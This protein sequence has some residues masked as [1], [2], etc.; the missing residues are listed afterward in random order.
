MADPTVPA[1]VPEPAAPERATQVAEREQAPLDELMLA[2]DV[3]DTL[4]HRELVVARELS[5]EDRERELMQRLREIYTG[6]G[7]EVSDEILAQGVRALRE[8]RFVYSGPEPGFARSLA[9]LYV[10]RG[11]WGKPLLALLAVVAAG[12]LGYQLIVR[13][14]ELRSI[15]QLPGQLQ[16]AQQSVAA[17]TTDSRALDEATDLLGIGQTAIAQQDYD[18]A[19]RAVA[20]LHDLESKLEQQYELRVVS[21][22]GERSGVWRVPDDNRNARNYYLIVEALA[23]SGRALTLPIRNEEDGRTYNVDKWGLRVDESTYEAIARDKQDDGIIQ[24]SVVGAK[25]RGALDPEFAVQTTGATIT[26]W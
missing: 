9:L 24:R 3:V 4:R 16:A 15:E 6:Q 1:R 17:L 18:A 19:Q 10:T 7:I 22:A 14:P 25:R 8:D 21:R 12:L 26:K 13:G 2:M 20:S 11:R 23:P 5:E